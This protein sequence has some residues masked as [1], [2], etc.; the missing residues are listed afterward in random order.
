MS[1]EDCSSNSSCSRHQKQHEDPNLTRAEAR[2]VKYQRDL[3]SSLAN[4]ASKRSVKRLNSDNQAVVQQFFGTGTEVK[5]KELK[6]PKHYLRSHRNCLKEQLSH[7]KSLQKPHSDSLQSKLDLITLKPSLLSLYKQRDSPIK[8]SAYGT[9]SYQSIMQQEQLNEQPNSARSRR[10]YQTSP[11][12]NHCAT[13]QSNSSLTGSLNHSISRYSGTANDSQQHEISKSHT[14]PSNNTL[15][16]LPPSGRRGGKRHNVSD[17]ETAYSPQDPY[18][19]I[20]PHQQGDQSKEI[21]SKSHALV[22]PF[23]SSYLKNRIDKVHFIY[24][25]DVRIAKHTKT[26]VESKPSAQRASTTESKI[27]LPSK[28]ANRARANTESIHRQALIERSLDGESSVDLEQ[29]HALDKNQVSI[30]VEYQAGGVGV[31]NTAIDQKNTQEL[32]KLLTIHQDTLKVIYSCS[33][34]G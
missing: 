14:P 6:T 3:D 21:H 10:N 18:L 20:Q 33:Y 24:N 22:R 8:D 29:L 12:S 25:M 30:G 7:T 31:G 17:S 9:H 27:T 19:I 5:R 11:V 34:F 1:R 23:N 32:S 16:R 13:S 15:S 26:K 28:K 2:K 4:L